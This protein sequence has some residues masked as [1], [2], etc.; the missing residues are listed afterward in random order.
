MG[1]YSSSSQASVFGRMNQ[2]NK[3]NVEPGRQPKLRRTVMTCW[4]WTG[5]W[6]LDSVRQIAQPRARRVAASEL[7]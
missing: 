4:M 6:H 5:L 7:A 1:Q 3:D 2:P